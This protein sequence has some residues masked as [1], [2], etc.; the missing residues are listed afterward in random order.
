MRTRGQ[1]PSSVP[2]KVPLPL[3]E[4][5][6]NAWEQELKVLGR[7]SQCDQPCAQ[8]MGHEPSQR[9]VTLVTSPSAA[10]AGDRESANLCTLWHSSA[11]CPIHSCQLNKGTDIQDP[12]NQ[13]SISRPA[14]P[15]ATPPLA[16]AQG[17]RVLC[18]QPLI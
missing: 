10:P 9:E 3:P 2:G 5:K 6:A 11:G 16:G 7:E 14:F 4:Q 1:T 18:S 8:G 17:L 15:P 12:P 13:T